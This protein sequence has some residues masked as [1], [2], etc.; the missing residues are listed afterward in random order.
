MNEEL[1][2]SEAVFGFAGWLITRREQTVMSSHDDAA[3]I[4]D[5]CGE[6]CG[7]NNLPEPRDT[8]PKH[9]TFPENVVK[10]Q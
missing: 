4:A 5:L 1:S 8:F 2:G 6:F 9:L 3:P 10:G 7:A